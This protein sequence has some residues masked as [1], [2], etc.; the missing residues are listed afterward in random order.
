MPW[1][2]YEGLSRSKK[3]LVWAIVFAAAVAVATIAWALGIRE[4][5]TVRS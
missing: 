2:D 1:I 3:I 4:T 5:P